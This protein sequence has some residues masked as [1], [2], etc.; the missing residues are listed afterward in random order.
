MP[1]LNPAQ[2]AAVNK[3]IGHFPPEIAPPRA[4]ELVTAI[5]AALADG[6]PDV[7]TPAQLGERIRGRWIDHGYA[8]Q[9]ADGKI[10]SVVGV[11][12]DLVRAYKRGDKYGCP[13]PRC[14][15]GA[16]IDTGEICRVCEVRIADRL[17][18]NRQ[19]QGQAPIGE[20]NTHLGTSAPRPVPTQRPAA[21]ALTECSGRNGICGR[22]VKNGDLCPRCKDD[23]EYAATT[24]PKYATAG[25]APF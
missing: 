3:V 14:E 15:N 22:P 24:G 7:R 2:W 13:D 25:N 23:V 19:E 12:I 8:Q 20:P 18:A 11:G 10:R 5:L 16:D 6:Q 4:P 21:L 1:K 9:H 17:A